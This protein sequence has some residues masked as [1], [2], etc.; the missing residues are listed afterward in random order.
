MAD[1]KRDAL[2]EWAEIREQYVTPGEIMPDSGE[3]FYIGGRLASDLRAARA[4]NERLRGLIDGGVRGWA[5]PLG[6][7][8]GCDTLRWQ[9]QRET[10]APYNWCGNEPPRAILI[11]PTESEER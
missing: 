1:E 6:D 11:F 3:L 2:A 7:Y 5:S 8:F 4:E 9:F 10:E